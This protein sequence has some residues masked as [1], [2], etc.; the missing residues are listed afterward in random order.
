[1]FPS[2]IN[3]IW[4]GIVAAISA[5]GLIVID[6]AN[7]ALYVVG[8]GIVVFTFLF[9]KALFWLGNRV[10]PP[11]VPNSAVQEVF[12]RCAS[13]AQDEDWILVKFQPGVSLEQARLKVGSPNY[14]ED[15]RLVGF[16]TKAQVV[17]PSRPNVA[18]FYSE[19]KG[20]LL[21]RRTYIQTLEKK[22]GRWMLDTWH[23]LVGAMSR[24]GMQ[25]SSLDGPQYF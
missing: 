5:L 6:P 7:R 14:S 9:F 24:V 2:R 12:E 11:P 21:A 1:M 20:Y 19:E 22:Y 16:M 25:V 4:L 23:S 3:P 8:V 15:D 17:A 13:S 10:N 18:I